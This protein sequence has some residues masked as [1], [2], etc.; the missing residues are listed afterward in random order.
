MYSKEQYDHLFYRMKKSI[1]TSSNLF[2]VISIIKLY[3]LFLL[4]HAAGYT[5]PRNEL[6]TIH[7]YFKFFS[8]TFYIHNSFNVPIINPTR[9]KNKP[10]LFV[11]GNILHINRQ[12]LFQKIMIYNNKFIFLIFE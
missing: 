5:I 4:S 6:S 9:N 7:T 12:K 3:P 8:L 10:K 2:L 1:P 11:L